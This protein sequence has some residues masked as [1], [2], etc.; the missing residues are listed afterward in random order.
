LRAKGTTRW[1]FTLRHRLPKGSYVL[2]VR[3]IDRAG[4][5]AGRRARVAFTVT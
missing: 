4:K 3:A 5:V 2:T 1:S